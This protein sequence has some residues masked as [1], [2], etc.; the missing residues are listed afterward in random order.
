MGELNLI[1]CL[2]DVSSRK[3]GKRSQ[4]HKQ[5]CCTFSSYDGADDKFNKYVTRPLPTMDSR[6][7]CLKV[8]KC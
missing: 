7:L 2:F 8:T 4:K 1:K 5:G 6:S 3:E